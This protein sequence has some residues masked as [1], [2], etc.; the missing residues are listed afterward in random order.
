MGI[1]SGSPVIAYSSS[2]IRQLDKVGVLGAQSGFPLS[3]AVRFPPLSTSSFSPRFR[4]FSSFFSSFLF[5][6]FFSCFVCS[7]FLCYFDFRAFFLC[8][9]SSD[10]HFSPSPVHHFRSFFSFALFACSPCLL[11]R[12]FAHFPC[13]PCSLFCSFGP[14]FC[15]F[16]FFA[17]FACSYCD[18]FFHSSSLVFSSASPVVSSGLV[19]Y[20]SHSHEVPPSSLAFFLNLPLFLFWI[21]RLLFLHSLL[22]VPLLLPLL[23]LLVRFFDTLL[24]LRLLLPLP[25]VLLARVFLSVPSRVL[26]VPLIILMMF[27]IILMMMFVRPRMIP[28]RLLSTRLRF[29]NGSKR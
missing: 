29:L 8:D 17:C 14:C 15:S 7:S 23:P 20:S 3:S 2:G 13:L 10:S 24:L 18:H 25:L 5:S 16:G 11:S 27:C 22:L 6:S 21:L 26:R 9:F 4:F 12:S 19:G 1:S 28:I